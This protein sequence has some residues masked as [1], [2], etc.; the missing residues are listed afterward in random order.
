MCSINMYE[1]KTNLS[2][3][4][5]LLESG[6]EKEIIL[7]KR[8]KRI[9]K[10]VLIEEEGAKPRLDAAKGFLPALDFDLDN[11]ELN[12]EIAKEFGY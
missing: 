1:A 2:K 11:K 8:G 3:Y 7:C 9:A 5:E 12:E 4:V 6:N 10:I